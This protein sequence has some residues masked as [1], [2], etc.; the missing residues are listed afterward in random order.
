MP[1]PLPAETASND[2]DALARHVPGI[3]PARYFDSQ[4]EDAWRE[5]ARRWP[6][7]GA[8][9]GLISADASRSNDTP[10]P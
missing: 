10:P 1:P 2:I 6:L 4:A 7:L 9:L 3:D 8:V 5:A